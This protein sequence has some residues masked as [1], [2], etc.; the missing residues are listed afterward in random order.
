MDKKKL[1]WTGMKWIYEHVDE[2]PWLEIVVEKGGRRVVYD[3]REIVERL[4]RL[5]RLVEK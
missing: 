1:N 5:E 4:E 3:M 2:D